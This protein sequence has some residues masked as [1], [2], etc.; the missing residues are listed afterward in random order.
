[1]NSKNQQKL[2]NFK[3]KNKFNEF[4]F[5]YYYSVSHSKLRDDYHFKMTICATNYNL[6]SHFFAMSFSEARQNSDGYY[7]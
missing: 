7:S 3:N 2:T 6:S 1:M 5:C 4:Y